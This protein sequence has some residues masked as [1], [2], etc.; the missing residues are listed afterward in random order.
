[1]QSVTHQG[2]LKLPRVHKSFRGGGDVP[3][4]LCIWGINPS[5]WEGD[6]SARTAAG[7][8]YRRGKSH[9]EFGWKTCVWK[10][11]SKAY[12]SKHKRETALEKNLFWKT[13]K[14]R[15]MVICLWKWKHYNTL[16]TLRLQKTCIDSSHLKTKGQGRFATRQPRSN[17]WDPFI[18]FGWYYV[19]RTLAVL[20]LG[21]AWIMEDE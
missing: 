19:L 12:D 3:N 13:L 2:R 4:I 5:K 16:S 18:S 6:M 21:C 14:P 7:C 1:M 8:T 17:S 20:S 11:C 10:L 9:F 15:V